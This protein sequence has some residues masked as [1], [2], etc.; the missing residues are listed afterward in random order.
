MTMRVVVLQSNYIPWKGYFDLLDA[1]DL[2]VLLD[3]VQY[4]HS[5]WRNRNRVKTPAGPRWLTIPVAKK[6]RIG[7]TID[8]TECSNDTWAASH[9]QT[10]RQSYAASPYWSDV[11]LVLG[12]EYAQPPEMLLS[13]SNRR[14]IRSIA[15]A[16]GIQTPIVD[17]RSVAADRAG[18][19]TQ[20]LVTMCSE[21][22]AT[23]YLSGPAARAYL[24]VSAFSEVGIDVAFANYESYP[25]YEQPHGEF[26]HGVSIID[27]IAC[28]GIE[29]AWEHML[30]R[31]RGEPLIEAVPRA[32]S[33][34]RDPGAPA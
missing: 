30:A 20:R 2:F 6:G 14:L 12:E 22:G 32:L 9:W 8:E 28:V 7:R 3:E 19:P 1:A 21:L 4:T 15:G 5:D 31:R 34:R 10:I 27:L 23:E 25:E 18:T 29:Q 16:L 24:D 17:S 26:E 13:A 33:A 11:Q